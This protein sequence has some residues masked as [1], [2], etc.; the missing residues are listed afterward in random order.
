MRRVSG[1]VVAVVTLTTVLALAV[2]ASARHAATI[3]AFTTAQLQKDPA[4]DWPTNMGNLQGTN[5]SSLAQITPANVAN[6]KVAWHTEL[7]APSLVASLPLLVG[8]ATSVPIAYNGVLY[9]EDQA[10]RV[11]ANDAATGKTLWVYDPRQ[12]SP[13]AQISVRGLGIGDGKVYLAD[14]KAVVTAIDANTGQKVW[15]TRIA[16][17]DL[18]FQFT[19]APLYW[20]GMLL[21]GTSG[22][23]LGASCFF[24]AMDAK[25]ARCSGT[26]T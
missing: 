12:D 11:F 26:S 21:T 7:S 20:N 13:Y 6:L 10:D 4:T 22:G 9:T 15:A 3:P 24:L 17:P 1:A 14:A 25:T 5:H 2:V 8:G 16:N 19:A 23:D 18:G